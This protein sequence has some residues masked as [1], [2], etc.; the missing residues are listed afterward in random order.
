MLGTDKNYVSLP[1]PIEL[2][3]FYGLGGLAAEM[4]MGKV[5]YTPTQASSKAGELISGLLPIDLLGEGGQSFVPSYAKPLVEAYWTN[6]NFMGI[7]IYKDTDFNKDMPEW[8]KAY[9]STSPE[10]ISMAKVIND[11]TGG[12]DYKKGAVDINPARV[13]HI[14]EGYFGGM[15]TTANQ[16]KNGLLMMTP[17]G[18]DLWEEP[19]RNLP[20]VNR[21]IKQ[22]NSRAEQKRINEEYFN[23]KSEMDILMQQVNGF[24]RDLQNP[25]K[26][27]AEKENAY[28]HYL[29]LTNSREYRIYEAWHEYDKALQKARKAHDEDGEYYFKEVMNEL[30]K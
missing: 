16:F 9:K 18:E 12:N 28:R 4:M 11:A 20:I 25:D 13:E 3:V 26:T 17:W 14:M 27:D 8:A 6:Q 29:E 22:S 15:A 7:P 1:L 2:R 30:F 24:K 23:N 19:A 21:F 5:R 10:M